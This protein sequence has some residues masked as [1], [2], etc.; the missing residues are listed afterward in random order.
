MSSSIKNI[1]VSNV[2]NNI[3]VL[4]INTVK[5]NVPEGYS[6]SSIKS[7]VPTYNLNIGRNGIS[8]P[9]TYPFKDQLAITINF[10]NEDSNA[11][12]TFDIQTVSNQAGWTANFAGLVQA[13]SDIL[14]WVSSVGGGGLATE[15]TLLLVKTA[16]ET[17][18][19]G[20]LRSLASFDHVGAG[21]QNTTA[22]VKTVMITCVNGVESINGVVRPAGIYT[23]EP[24][25]GEDTVDVI[26]LNPNAGGRIIVDELS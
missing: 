10:H 24:Q 4:V 17:L 25:K 16:V 9:T 20:A 15:A 2:G 3:E 1:E 26:G 13:V 7:V 23:F 18:A 19:T 6:L 22:G 11:P 5:P 21:A 12:L 8:N 14:G